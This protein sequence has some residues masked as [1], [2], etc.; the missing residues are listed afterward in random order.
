[1]LDLAASRDRR[2][3][4]LATIRRVA[5]E[6]AIPLTAGGGIR[7]LDDARAVIR[8]GADKITVNTAAVTRPELITELSQEFGAQAGVVAIVAKLES[9]STATFSSAAVDYSAL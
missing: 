4:F 2:P 6:L 8:A 1:M 5:A 7:S 3:T 9:S